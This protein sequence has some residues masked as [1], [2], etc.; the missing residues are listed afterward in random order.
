MSV[1]YLDLGLLCLLAVAVLAISVCKLRTTLSYKLK[2]L[3]PLLLLFIGSVFA[4]YYFLGAAAPVRQKIAT[5]QSKK[6][7]EE[8][9]SVEQIIEKL[10]KQLHARPDARGWYLL[11]RLYLH[12]NQFKEAATAFAEGMKLAPADAELK[13]QYQ[14]ALVWEKEAK[15]IA[16]L[17]GITVRVTMSPALQSR[18]SPETVVFVL[19]K[20]PPMPMPIAA[21][22]VYV[23]NLP[24]T[25]RFTDQ[26]ML[27][28]GKHLVDYKEI[29]V[30]ARTALSGS[31]APT[32]GDFQG[33]HKIKNW[34]LQQQPV[35]IFIAEPLEL[36]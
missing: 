18:F 11:G 8:L 19:L 15:E 21:V 2:Y 12:Q 30:M 36:K 34:K 7:T 25:V 3:I 5:I 13:A 20:A 4:L 16:K 22:K 28:P 14:Q 6:L 1:F 26:S 24:L 32:Q 33:Q 17:P 27:I 29:N 9:G 23:K 10:K 31:V 35:S